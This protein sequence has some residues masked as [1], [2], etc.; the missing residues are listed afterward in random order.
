MKELNKKLQFEFVITFVY[1]VNNEITYQCCYALIV[2]CNKIILNRIPCSIDS[3][4]YFQYQWFESIYKSI[5]CN[6]LVFL[7]IFYL[8]FK[9]LYWMMVI[10]VIWDVEMPLNVFFTIK[11]KRFLL[12]Q[13][14]FAKFF[15]NFLIFFRPSA[16]YFDEYFYHWNC[17]KWLKYLNI[18]SVSYS[19]MSFKEIKYK[20]RISCIFVFCYFKRM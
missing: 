14:F 15:I 16:N 12:W 2:Q 18:S 7:L 9:A 3:L 11:V 4:L 13:I 6:K 5:I 10:S 8:S 17:G 19:L 20:Q 1:F